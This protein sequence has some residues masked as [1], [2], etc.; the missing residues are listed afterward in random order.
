MRRREAGGSRASRPRILPRNIQPARRLGISLPIHAL[1]A[2]NDGES[3]TMILVGDIG[4]TNTRL[5]LYE[6][7]V[8]GLALRQRKDFR[9]DDHAGL[10][11]LL[12]AF[13]ADRPRLQGACFG[14][15]GLVID[16]ACHLTNRDWLIEETT[17]AR[18]L[19]I[20]VRL[21]NDVAAIASGVVHLSGSGF[22]E[23][24]QG[25]RPWASGNIAVVAPGT[26]LGEA[27]AFWDGA[28]H[29]P[30]AS[31]AGH[32]DFAPVDAVELEL[33]AF[34]HARY[35]GHA[36]VERVLSGPGLAVIADFL[37]A[38]GRFAPSP[39]V[40]ALEMAHRPAELVRL[41]LEG[42]QPLA[43]ATLDIF[44]SVLAR[45]A[46]NAALR[47]LALGGIVL[48]GGIPPRLL[49]RL[50]QPLFI[51]TLTDKGRFSAMLRS[52]PVRVVVD[53]DASLLGAAA[54]A[55]NPSGR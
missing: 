16:G 49:S 45:E 33:A 32:A 9:N 26:G 25:T 28:R 24:Q 53:N 31:E 38:S 2:I 7:S 5:A 11:T 18:R 44:L 21:V 13:L 4:G 43:L 34:L 23:L 19:G 40:V 17:L 22:V 41:A 54:I 1:N 42:Q 14:V 3:E 55:S 51:T 36:S 35:D 8:A 39:T 15:A 10:D 6:Q 27:C 29:R 12:D 47:Y 20:P 30:F 37:V 48:G 52:L 50:R 46:G